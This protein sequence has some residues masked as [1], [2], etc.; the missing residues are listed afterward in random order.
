[1]L[2]AALFVACAPLLWLFERL[3]ARHR[4]LALR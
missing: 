4:G 1:L 2:G 3:A